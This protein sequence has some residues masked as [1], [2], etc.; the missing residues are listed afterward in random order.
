VIA[1]VI[2]LLVGAHDY[3]F[4]YRPSIPF[5]FFIGAW[6]GMFI[7]QLLATMMLISPILTTIVILRRE[8]RHVTLLALAACTAI[9]IP[10]G[11]VAKIHA[12][13]HPA[14]LDTRIRTRHELAAKH[15]EK[16]TKEH[17]S[18]CGPDDD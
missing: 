17:R 4:N 10:L 18:D 9:T 14:V 11:V 8:R 16:C 15:W 13:Q 1:V 6:I 12:H 2:M 5:N 7:M 3:W